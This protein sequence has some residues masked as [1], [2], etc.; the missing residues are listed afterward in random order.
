MEEAM[1]KVPG[2]R[3][4]PP[5][6]T[7]SPQLC[8]FSSSSHL[9]KSLVE[10]RNSHSLRLLSTPLDLPLDNQVNPANHWHPE[11]RPVSF[12]RLEFLI[13][14]IIQFLPRIDGHDD[15]SHAICLQLSNAKRYTHMH[16]IN[17]FS[18]D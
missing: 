4:T 14:G 17:L 16:N 5:L 3:T 13:S 7:C 15:H 2:K 10:Y 6:L 18:V 12:F 1:T 9:G 11:P 8:Q